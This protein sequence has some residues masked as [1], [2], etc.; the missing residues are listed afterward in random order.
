MEQLRPRLL[1]TYS[2]LKGRAS[3][4]GRAGG[5]A[6]LRLRPRA[7][8]WFWPP[9]DPNRLFS[10]S[11]SSAASCSSAASI[12][13]D[14][15]DP[16]FR[17]PAIKGGKKKKKRKNRGPPKENRPPP[18]ASQGS[19]SRS[20]PFVPPTPVHRN[21]TLRRPQKDS[22]LGPKRPTRLRGT[23]LLCSTPE[24][25][26]LTQLGA[27][28][29]RALQEEEGEEKDPQSPVSHPPGCPGRPWEVFREGSRDSHHGLLLE[30]S[31]L[32]MDSEE[33]PEMGD[34]LQLFSPEEAP[35]RPQKSP[36]D[37]SLTD[38]ARL[39]GFR[40]TTGSP[41]QSAL[42]R[43]ETQSGTEDSLVRREQSPGRGTD[44]DRDPVPS[45]VT[46][47]SPTARSPVCG[48]FQLQ[49]RMQDG[50]IA[51]SPPEGTVFL[52]LERELR[53][54]QDIS[55]PEE[56]AGEVGRSDHGIVPDS[57][58]FQPVVILDEQVV[59]KWLA[60]QSARKPKASCSLKR[61]NL[62]LAQSPHILAKASDSRNNHRVAPSCNPGGTG[63]KACISGFSSKRWGRQKVNRAAHRQN[64]AWKEADSLVLQERLK[65]NETEDQLSVAFLPLDSSLK[66]S[67]L[68]RRI[69]ASFSLHKKKKILSEAESLKGSFASYSS[70]QSP[71]HDVCNTPF[72]QKLGYSI[73][74]SSSMVLLSS[75]TSLSTL[76]TTLTDAEKVYRECQQ[77]G[78]VSFEDWISQKK[79]PKCEKIGEGVFGEVFKTET[80]NGTV[81][82]KIIP[83]EGSER[84]NG[85]P[86]KTFTEILPEIIIS[87]EL[88]LLADEVAN[89]TSGFIRLYSV[90]CVQG[91]YPEHLLNAWDEYHRL[92]QS[93]NN[94][95]DFFSDQQLF[96]V[97]EFEFGGTDLEN[98]RN[99]QLNSVASAKSI[100]H[101]VTASLAVAEEALRFEHRDLHW[102][103]VLVRKTSLKEVAVTLNGQVHVLPTQGILVNIIDYTFSR[104]ERDGL[105]VFCDLSTDEEV[106]QG[107]G[108]Y[109]FDIYRQMREEN[110]NNWADYFP[111][112]N[113]L[114]L[115]YLADKLLKEVSYKKKATSSSLKQVQKQLRLFSAK[116]LNF[117]S[118]TELL[119][120]GTFFQ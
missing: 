57:L 101:Q 103:N 62:F 64:T 24:W 94:R 106:F 115:H 50:K 17:P 6:E 59:L 33:G 93:E 91:T 28:R 82:L 51:L 45:S 39:E 35:P 34:S 48:V 37:G 40:G 42:Q 60:D 12:N 52:P 79:M 13:G 7:T 88:S 3:R 67:S 9:A 5:K 8:P 85:E 38:P 32:K 10:T 16:D 109:Q 90:H 89:R 77:E 98:M 86:Q 47:A 102:G 118:A 87:K 92:R 76:E 104:L 31:M 54:A 14:D 11:S 119:N 58:Q 78:P 63:R 1:R 36:G 65:W 114:W 27:K 83:I 105:T 18:K 110:A 56:M 84:V 111:H 100:L 81:A 21:V 2:G 43:D 70:V 30:L 96:M 107:R 108:D 74:P 75:M 55:A 44:R 19:S 113:I 120:L 69:R 66:N 68:W 25:P 73:C 80:E 112:S 95:P 97:L 20:D 61:K 99:R 49:A 22:P 15:D 116:V 71:L 4:G 46:E 26:L 72:T 29:R 53:F 41:S 117:K 23:P